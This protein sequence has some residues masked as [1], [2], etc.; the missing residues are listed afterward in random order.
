MASI[1]KKNEDGSF[2]SPAS[3]EAVQIALPRSAVDDL[4]NDISPESVSAASRKESHRASERKRRERL[5][6]SM[7]TLDGIIRQ[8]RKF[9]NKKNVKLDKNSI[10]EH[11]IGYIQELQQMNEMYAKRLEEA[12]IQIRNLQRMLMLNSAFGRTL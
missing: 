10:I 8:T 7:S 9:A 1:S 11:A 12:S 5:S 4:D 2:R 6:V 3:V